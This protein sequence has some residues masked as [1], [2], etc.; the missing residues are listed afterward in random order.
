MTEGFIVPYS[1]KTKYF[2]FA[3]I[4]K[5]KTEFLT[6]SYKRSLCNINPIAL[7]RA[8]LVYKFG[9]SECNRF[10]WWIGIKSRWIFLKSYKTVLKNWII[11][12]YILPKGLCIKNVWLA[13]PCQYDWNL[14]TTKGP[15]FKGFIVKWEHFHGRKCGL[16]SVGVFFCQEQYVLIT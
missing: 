2:C 4:Q 8:K 5:G 11:S 16:G 14:I 15:F 13:S 7:R 10:K 6:C 1:Y 9:L 3:L 12:C